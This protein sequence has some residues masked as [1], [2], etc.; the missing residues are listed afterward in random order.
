MTAEATVLIVDDE[1]RVLDSL[2]ALLA[3]DYRVLRA[4]RPDAALE[5]LAHEAVALVISDQRM[6]GMSGTELLARCREVAPETVR[7]LLTAFTDADALMQS[8]N[9][10]NIYHFILKPWDPTELTHTVRRG[11][12]RHRLAAERERLLRDLAAKN[13][14][15][16]D[17]GRPPRDQTAS[18]ARLVRAP[19]R[20]GVLPR[21]ADMAL[22]NPSLL[23]SRDWREARALRRHPRYTPHRDHAGAVV[24]RLLD[25]YLAE[26]IEVI[27]RHQGTVEQLIGDEIV[28]LFGITEGGQ[29]APARAVRA[30]VDMVAAVSALAA[31]WRADGLPTFDIGVGLSS[32][33]L[34]A[35]TIGSDRRRELIVVGR[36]MIAAARIQRM[37]RLFDAHI[38][39]GEGTFRDVRDLVRYRELGTPKLKGIKVR[40]P[41]YEILG[42]NGV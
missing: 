6:P 24:I 3:M 2:E 31:R 20:S 11:V 5:L 40:E 17:A 18:C 37:T 36:P 13:T 14:D 27:F 29:D 26:M 33:R 28:A 25:G 19:A 32:G 4:D 34:W 42:L 30:G 16:E 35:A 39:A 1:A 22:G 23:D 41:L 15:L 38:I 7:V 10:A 8:I 9:A 21:L 12:E